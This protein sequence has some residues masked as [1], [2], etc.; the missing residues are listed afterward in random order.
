MY[1]FGPLGLPLAA[2]TGC[3]STQDSVRWRG[4]LSGTEIQPESSSSAESKSPTSSCFVK[5]AGGTSTIEA[6]EAL[7]KS[8]SEF[9]LKF[10]S[11]K[12]N[13]PCG[14]ARLS[15]E[16][17]SLWLAPLDCLGSSGLTAACLRFVAD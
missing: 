17:G 15:S 4:C 1:G 3:C 7:K 9:T 5:E 13:S 6:F 8:G 11:T 14:A 12:T 16:V 10:S 2:E